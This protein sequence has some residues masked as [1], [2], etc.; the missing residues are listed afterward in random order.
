ME[1]YNKEMYE[2]LSNLE[3]LYVGNNNK[4]QVCPKCNGQGIVSKPPWVAGYVDVWTDNA[5]SHT[6]DVCNGQKIILMS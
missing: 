4:Y 2:K 5:T 6:C 3:K 1:N